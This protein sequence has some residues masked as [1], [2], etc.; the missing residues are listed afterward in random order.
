M[1]SMLKFCPET[2]DTSKM[3]VIMSND[4][5]IVLRRLNSKKVLIKVLG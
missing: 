2:L 4:L 3:D 1:S 5:I